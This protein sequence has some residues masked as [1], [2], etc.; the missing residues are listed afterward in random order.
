MCRISK[1]PGQARA[2]P[3]CCSYWQT[4]MTVKERAILH[5]EWLSSGCVV[6]GTLGAS[7]SGPKC[8]RPPSLFRRLRRAVPPQKPNPQ[9]EH[10]PRHQWL[11]AHCRGIAFCRFFALEPSEN[12]RQRP[13]LKARLKVCLEVSV[14]RDVNAVVPLLR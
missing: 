2:W 5:P 10:P 8:L 4:R 6:L 7:T 3:P 11:A 9:S 1:M 13:F 12:G 14:I